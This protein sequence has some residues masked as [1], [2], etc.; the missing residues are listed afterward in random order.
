MEQHKNLAEALFAAQ[1]E[2]PKLKRDSK[3]PHFQSKYASLAGAVEQLEPIL[4]NHGLMITQPAAGDG[5]GTGCTTILFHVPTNEK[6]QET[7]LLPSAGP[8]TAANAQT[9]TAAVTYAKRTAYISMVGAIVEEDDDG[10]RA[11]R[12]STKRTEPAKQPAKKTDVSKQT[13]PVSTKKEKA[14][15]PVKADKEPAKTAAKTDPK[16]KAAA[17]ASTTSK[18]EKS[19]GGGESA[20]SAESTAKPPKA[21]IP[22][23]LPG[24]S[25]SSVYPNEAEYDAF[26]ARA[27]A[28]KEKL[29]AEG[30]K[31]PGK[32][33]STLFM[34]KA[35]VE[36]MKLI[37]KLTMEA[38]LQKIEKM[39]A[40]PKLLPQ[41][42]KFVNE[43]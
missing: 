33:L 19:V 43:A 37:P 23:E 14:S 3:N 12:T 7:L 11:V 9:G 39:I 25:E 6:I 40:D 21:E 34:K 16:A 24:V 38:M 29:G 28:V 13:Q 2:F 18:V 32:K 15:E 10:N 17:P 41:A 35:G 26:K 36:E 30:V 4:R 31:E 8:G 1:A 20:T 27:Q 5:V 22:T 42:I